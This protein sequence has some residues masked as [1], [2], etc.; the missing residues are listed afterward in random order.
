MEMGNETSAAVES[1]QTA[2]IRSTLYAVLAHGFSYPGEP[3][4]EFFRRCDG[5]KVDGAGEIGGR[6]NALLESA[7]ST[8]LAALQHEYMHLF[9]PLNGVFPYEVE[10]KKLQDFSKAQMM[11]DVMGFYRAFGVE[12]CTERPD[13]IAAELEF[14]HFLALKESH[15]L[16]KGEIENAAVCR[17][18]QESFFSDHL[19]T[20]IDALLEQMRTYSENEPASFYSHLGNLMELF[21]E[22][23]KEDLK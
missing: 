20:W 23:E 15:A 6:L 19:A 1:V 17:E 16:G 12:P 21:M 18:A 3:V 7:R 9:D 13:H 4:I 14:M 2:A 5:A 8:E 22:H 10:L 11:A